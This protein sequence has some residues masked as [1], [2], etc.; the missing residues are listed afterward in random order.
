MCYALGALVTVAFYIFECDYLIMFF[1]EKNIYWSTPG[2]GSLHGKCPSPLPCQGPQH[3]FLS[4]HLPPP[5]L[6][7]ILYSQGLA[8]LLTLEC[9]GASMAHWDMAHC[10]LLLLDSSDPPALASWLAGTI[11][12]CCCAQPFLRLKE[13]NGLFQKVVLELLTSESPEWRGGFF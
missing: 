13:S 5:P 12:K 4:N 8:L 9:S 10:S 6:P 7:P 1:H 2:S 11:G 3:W